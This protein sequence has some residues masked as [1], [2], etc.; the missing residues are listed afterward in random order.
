LGTKKV[1]KAVFLDRDGTIARDVPYC[2][3]PEDF[4]LLPGVAEGIKLLN[5]HGFKVVIVTNQSGIARGYFTEEMLDEIHDKMIT[6]LAEHGARADAIYYCPHHPDDNCACRK[7]KPKMVF[8]AARDLDID[9][10][11]SYVIGDSEMDIEL[12]RRAGC[13]AGIRVGEP[14]GTGDWVT[15]S[16]RDAVEKIIGFEG[17]S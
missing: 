6:Q 11:Q 16:F 15:A 13:K 3:R 8:Q 7:P 5:E 1:H 12:A 14:G 17:H 10:S 2:S 4:E 9:P